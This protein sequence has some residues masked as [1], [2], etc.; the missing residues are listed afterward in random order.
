M[1][2]KWAFYGPSGR[3]TTAARSVSRRAAVTARRRSRKRS[4]SQSRL[5]HEAPVAQHPKPVRVSLAGQQ[6]RRALAHALGVFAPQEPPVVEEEPKQLQVSP[7]HL[8]AQE[9]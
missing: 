6:L 7:A 2:Q 9:Q 5:A 4:G 8:L 3:A 1:V